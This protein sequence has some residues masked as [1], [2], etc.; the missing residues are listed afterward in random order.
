MTRLVDM[1]KE[2]LI[3]FIKHN[4]S[5]RDFA[6]LFNEAELVELLEKYGF[7]RLETLED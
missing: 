6:E 3:E 1:D 2:Q 7:S 4:I 5:I